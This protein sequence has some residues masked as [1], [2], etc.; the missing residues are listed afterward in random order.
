MKVLAI[1]TSSTSATCAIIHEDKLL[2]EYT[3]NHKLTHSQK[4]MPIIQEALEGCELKVSDIDIFAVAKGPGSFTGLRIGVATIKGLAQAVNKSVV[5]IPTLDALAFNLPYCEGIVVPVMDARRDR[6]FTAIYKWTNGNLH[7]IKEQT[8]LEIEELIDI[9]K[10]RPETV[11]FVGDGTLVYKQRLTEELGEKARFA[12]KSAN[13]ARASS[14]AELAMAKAKEG[15]VESF[16]DLAPDYLRESQA[17]REYK[18][19]HSLSG[20]RDE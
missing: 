6:V 4:I 12:P 15:K 17:Q 14:V 2:V 9:L 20:D 7:I 16:L 13:M 10:E 11:V 8:V 19:K 3:L 5:G 1:D 18:E